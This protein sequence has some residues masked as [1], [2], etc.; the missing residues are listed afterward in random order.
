LDFLLNL[1]AIGGCQIGKETT[2]YNMAEKIELPPKYYLDNFFELLDFLEQHAAHLLSAEEQQFIARFQH[3]PEAAQCLFLRLMNRKGIFFREEKLAYPEIEDIPATLRL[4]AQKGFVSFEL[5]LSA[6]PEVLGLFT[7]PELLKHLRAFGGT[8]GAKASIRKAELLAMLSGW[9]QLPEFLGYLLTKQPVVKQHFAYEALWLQFLYFGNL[10]MDMSRFVIR[11]V[12]HLRFH[13]ADPASFRAAFSS[14][15]AA[16]QKLQAYLDYEAFRE[17]REGEDMAALADFCLDTLPKTQAVADDARGIYDRMA[18]K[19]AALLERQGYT[20]QAL[21]VYRFTESPPSRERQVRILA[22]MGERQAAQQLCE[23]MLG[24]GSAAEEQVFAHDFLQK[25][26]GQKQVRSAR[27]LQKAATTISI[28]T[29]YRYSVEHGALSYFTDCGFEGCITENYLWRNLTGLLFWDILFEGK[30]T[31]PLQIVPEGLFTPT[32]YKQ[33]KKALQRRLQM[34]EDAGTAL[35][36]LQHNF[37]EKHGTANPFVGWHEL[38]MYGIGLLL[39]HVEGVAIAQL[40]DKICQNLR[41]NLRGF[42][43]LMVCKSRQLTFYEVKSPH[44]SLSDHQLYWIRQ[45][46]KAGLDAQVLNVVW[47][48]AGSSPAKP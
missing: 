29:R 15:E 46:N 35:R 28:P 9:E 48:E 8:V 26:Q 5:E 14:R 19:A 40:L 37:E 31:G 38:T 17:L 3:L 6:A 43:D 32:F 24:E 25:L 12:G 34:L 23:R 18:I 39:Q 47:E 41:R 16:K 45:M 30:L 7:K 36:F 42:P 22:K 13:Q 20:Q 10:E 11:D 2:V 33:N 21:A 4:L 27:A 1:M 44:D